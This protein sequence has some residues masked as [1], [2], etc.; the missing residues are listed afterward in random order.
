MLIHRL[1][2]LDAIIQANFSNKAEFKDFD[3]LKLNPPS[4]LGQHRLSQDFQVR[5]LPSCL[6]GFHQNL[7]ARP[8]VLSH[9][10]FGI[11]K[12]DIVYIG[13]ESATKFINVLLP[14]YERH[15]LLHPESF[16]AILS[17]R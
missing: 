2:L 4:L 6:F 17:S 8:S 5:N 1:S 3:F 14:A 15:L 13:I 7:L 12:E 9:T 10:L 11:E 16:V